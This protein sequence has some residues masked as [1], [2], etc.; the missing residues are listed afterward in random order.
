M[1]DQLEDVGALQRVAAGEDEERNLELGDLVDEA[2]RLH[3]VELAGVR[4]RLRGGAAV[5]AGE[6][7][8]LRGFPNREKRRAIVV[9]LCHGLGDVHANRLAGSGPGRM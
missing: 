1:P 9:E 7:A 4:L 8:C 5:L 2:G 3:G 6:V